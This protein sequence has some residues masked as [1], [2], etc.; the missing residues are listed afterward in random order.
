M[1][2]MIPTFVLILLFVA[3]SVMA[4]EPEEVQFDTYH[5][6]VY[7]EFLGAHILGGVNFDMR[8]NKGRMDGIGFRAGIGGLS[9][10]TTDDI[11]S[12]SM[13][14][15]LVT[16]PLEVNHLYGK[17][18]SSFISGVGLLPVYATASI[19]G[20]STD[21]EMIRAD[22]FGIAGGFLTLGYRFQPLKSGVMFQF[23]WNPMIL[24]GSGFN[25]GWFGL[26]L[27]FGF[28]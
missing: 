21:F 27:G 14:V 15:G 12:N 7:G 11:N 23:N 25:G 26:G 22:G 13:S 3:S 5:K 2:R 8:L 10:S 24:R 17:R 1:R 4:N 18:R 6:N 28:K 9:I 19:S 16:F 20:S